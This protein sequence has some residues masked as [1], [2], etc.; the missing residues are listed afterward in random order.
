MAEGTGRLGFDGFGTTGSG[1]TTGGTAKVTALG[2]T[3]VV[4]TIAGVGLTVVGTAALIMVVLNNNLRNQSIN[5]LT[6]SQLINQSVI[7]QSINQ[8][9]NRSI[10]RSIINQ[11]IINHS[12]SQSIKERSFDE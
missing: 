9:I 6:M 2:W 7:N 12:I 4:R 3:G 8:L 11:S 1:G 5:Q 10:A